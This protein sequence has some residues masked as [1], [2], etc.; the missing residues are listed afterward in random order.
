MIPLERRRD[1]G[2]NDQFFGPKLANLSLKLVKNERRRKNGEIEKHEF[3]SSIW[4]KAKDQLLIETNDK[5]AY[6]ETPTAVVDFGDVEH[7][8]P[9]SLYWWLAYCLD[10]Y[11]VSCAICNQKF[12]SNRF[13]KLKQKLR[14]PR[15]RAND[16]DA[17]LKVTAAKMVPDPLDLPAVDAFVNLH[18]SEVPLLLNPYIDNPG[19]F[20]AWHADMTLREVELVAADGNQLAQDCVRE[21]KAVYG[22]DRPQLRRLRFTTFEAYFTVRVTLGDPGI[23]M[24]TRETNEQ[25][26]ANML[27]DEHPYAGMLR[28]FEGSG[29]PE[30]WVNGGFLTV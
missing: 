15:V 9:K 5:C 1:S 7:Y 26:L 17:K 4:G 28:F 19:D 23:S 16:T 20:F 10:N 6:C 27:L 12:K 24:Q 2:I 25:T 30:D 3:T 18:G 8:R 14:A 22:L 11:L 29:T 21:A 13:P